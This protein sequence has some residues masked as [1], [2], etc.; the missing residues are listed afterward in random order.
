MF[1]V[2]THC[3]VS[4]CWYEPVES[5]VSQM[6]RHGVDKA[7]LIQMLGQYD[8]AYQFECEIR[9]PGR[10]A[11]V[12]LVDTLSPGASERLENLAEQ[13]ARGVRLRPDDPLN[14]W[15][16]AADL[17]LVVSC[18]GTPPLFASPSFA[19]ILESLPDLPVI[20]EHLGGLTVWDASMTEPVKESVLAL[21]RFPNAYMKIHGLGEFCQRRMPVTNSYPFDPAGLSLLHRACDAFTGRVMWGSDFPPVSFREGYANALHLTMNELGSRPAT[22]RTEIFG[23]SCSGHIWTRIT[24]STCVEHRPCVQPV[25]AVL[26]CFLTD[27]VPP[28]LHGRTGPVQSQILPNVKKLIRTQ[29]HMA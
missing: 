26:W 18:I 4:P 7:V 23:G 2:D 27:R 3:H 24:V 20:I 21:S 25:L 10:F 12:I 16:S 29:Q 22:E 14:I 28:V 11:S 6:D 19:E 1:I 9:Y 8:N 17:G 15:H 13:G 5:L